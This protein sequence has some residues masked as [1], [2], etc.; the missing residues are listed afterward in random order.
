MS[1]NAHLPALIACAIRD[2]VGKGRARPMLRTAISSRPLCLYRRDNCRL[3]Y[4]ARLKEDKKAGKRQRDTIGHHWLCT[5]CTNQRKSGSTELEDRLLDAKRLADSAYFLDRQPF[6][7]LLIGQVQIL[8][9]CTRLGIL[10]VVRGMFH[11]CFGTGHD[12]MF[13]PNDEP[14]STQRF[15]GSLHLLCRSGNIKRHQAYAFG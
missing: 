1:Q 8:I 3:G 13:A 14:V 2:K 11:R 7:A 4:C 9:S 15:K 6:T 5:G 12:A 10:N